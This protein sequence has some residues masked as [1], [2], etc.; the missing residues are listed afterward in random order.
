MQITMLNLQI[1]SFEA[2]GKACFARKSFVVAKLFINSAPA[3]LS[4]VS[5]E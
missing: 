3:M 4:F 2:G 5:M 1:L